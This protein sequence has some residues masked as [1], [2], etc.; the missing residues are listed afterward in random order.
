M[1]RTYYDSTN[2]F[3]SQN[4]LAY[5][6]PSFWKT[7]SMHKSTV[8]MT[9]Q[10][11]NT[12]PANNIGPNIDKPEKFQTFPSKL[13]TNIRIFHAIQLSKDKF[14]I[15]QVYPIETNLNQRLSPN[16]LNGEGFATA[17]SVTSADTPV[18]I[19]ALQQSE[20]SLG[21]ATL[22]LEPSSK[23]VSG[24]GGTAISSPVSRAILRKNMGTRVIYRPE[25]VAVAGVGGTAHAQSDLI[26]DYVE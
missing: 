24:N 6:L 21:G 4:K 11:P 14:D 22:I 10:R 13:D 8:E 1:P 9:T 5:N 23:A 12:S 25:S 7:Q 2:F 17:T 26:L 20:W 16:V 18:S 15:R 19:P 3:P